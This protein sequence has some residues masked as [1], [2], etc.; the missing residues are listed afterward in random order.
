ML[1]RF[2][3][4][5]WATCLAV[6]TVACGGASSAPAATGMA[7]KV[8]ESTAT[9]SW[10]MVEGVEYWL[11]FGPTSQAPASVDTMSRWITLPNFTTT[12]K[13]T[14]PLQI[15]GLASGLSYSFTVNG[16]IN[17][18][19]GGPGAEPVVATP[20]PAGS[21]WVAGAA[22]AGGRDLRAIT[23]GTAFVAG[24]ANGAIVSSSDGT[25]WSTA[26]SSATQNLNAATYWL[27]YFL[28][29]DNGTL[30]T[31]TD[32]ATWTAQNSG[33]TQHLYGL[34]TNSSTRV[35]AVGANG[36]ILSSTD[37]VSWVASASGTTNHLYAVNY[38]TYNSGTWTAVGAAGT[39]LTSADGLTW[40][41][42]VSNSSADLLAVTT[43]YNSSTLV[44]VL[45]ASG[46]G[47]TIVTSSDATAWA[48][49][50]LPGA[51]TFNAITTGSQMVVVGN[52]GAIFT[53]TDGVTWTA[54]TP[55]PT[56]SNL[57]GVA[58]GNQNYVSVG[59]GGANLLA[60]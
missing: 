59:S 2:L 26:S 21:S 23:Y 40:T 6:L 22:A 50:T 29:G 39:I 45:A 1:A 12:I 60:N 17:G 36:T 5:F 31:S 19:P 14:S 25:T 28:A 37:G 30:L 3:K 27:R 57:L 48:V 44:Y 24:G 51:G 52:A 18:G 47:G 20:R 34:A 35:V 15:T 13:V 49:Q 8:G 11:F 16:R 33:S 55:A 38:S 10:N 54:V 53:S 46:T 4:F 32:A 7:V 43:G 56:T 42:K 58:R 41:T 9:L